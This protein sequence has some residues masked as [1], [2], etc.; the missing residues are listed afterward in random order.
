MLFP[1]HEGL[2]WCQLY[3]DQYC[4][5]TGLP[6]L[7]SGAGRL[8]I[9]HTPTQGYPECFNNTQGGWSELRCCTEGALPFPDIGWQYEGNKGDKL[10]EVTNNYYCKVANVS[11]S[12]RKPIECTLRSSE[13]PD[14]IASCWS[15]PVDPPQDLSTNPQPTES[16]LQEA[17]S[18]QQPLPTTST[19]QGIISNQ[20]PAPTPSTPQVTSLF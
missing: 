18:T 5:M 13:F 7:E 10:V 11:S 16:T 4:N 9:F 8:R 6:T 1:D 17:I 2:Y 20:H 15:Q 19:P 3:K 14:Y 12:Y